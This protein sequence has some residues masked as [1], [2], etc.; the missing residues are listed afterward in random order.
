MV[1]KAGLALLA[2]VV[3]SACQ[4]KVKDD[5]LVIRDDDTLKKFMFPASRDMVWT[6]R[7]ETVGLFDEVATVSI[8]VETL[9]KEAATLSV[10]LEGAAS[11]ELVQGIGFRG[12]AELALMPDGAVQIK[13]PQDDLTYFPDGRVESKEGLEFELLGTETVKTPAGTFACVKYR[14]RR[15]PTIDFPMTL[16]GTQW[17]GKG[18]GLVKAV[19]TVEGFNAGT[20]TTIELL[21]LER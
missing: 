20:R 2:L 7:R 14:V 13:D 18:T 11:G 15:A 5:P 4:P 6:Y 19:S 16:D 1:R 17:W 3:L 8:A 12:D 10:A 21:S 9:S